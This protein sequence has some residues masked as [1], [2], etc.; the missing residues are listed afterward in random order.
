MSAEYINRIVNEVKFGVSQF[1][2]YLTYIL[3][4]NKGAL[5]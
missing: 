3:I 5:N 2:L 1:Y 4:F